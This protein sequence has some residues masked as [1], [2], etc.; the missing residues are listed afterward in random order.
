MRK[1]LL[2]AVALMLAFA[3]LTGVALAADGLHTEDL[4]GALTPDDL[5][6]TLVG[7]GV[8]V[9]GAT[10]TG[11]DVASGLFTGGTGIVGFEEGLLLTSGNAANVIG[12]NVQDGITGDNAAP[13]DAD[14][15]ALIPQ[16]T[17]DASVLEFEF[18]ADADTVYFEYVFASDEYNEYVNTTFNDVFAFFVNGSNCAVAGDPEVPVSVN[19]INGGNPFGTDSTNPSLYINNDLSDGGGSI[20]TEMDGLTVVLVCESVVNPAPA[21]N[22]MKLAIADAGDFILDSAVFIKAGSLSTT[23]PESGTINIVKTV[24][25]QPDGAFDDD[26]S[27]WGFSITGVDG[28]LAEGTSDAAGLVS[29]TDV[30]VGDYDITETPG[31]SGMW[32]VGASCVD[33]AGAP[34]GTG[35]DGVL[36]GAGQSVTGVTVAADA[37][38]T[39]SFANQH[40]AGY[41]TGGGMILDNDDGKIKKQKDFDKVGFGGNVGAAYDGTLHGQMQVNLHNVSVDDLDKGKFH[42]TSI[43]AVWFEELDGLEPAAPP[44]ALYNYVAYSATGR[45]N[46]EDGW[47]IWAEVTDHG[48]PAS[49][50]NAGV[51]EDTYRVQLFNPGGVLVY[52]SAWDF[53]ADA[54]ERTILDN[55]NIQI[56]PL[57]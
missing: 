38:I 22:T 57:D 33:E 40:M 32:V 26:P 2:L 9:S 30:P 5:A 17:N 18:T 36:V 29:F 53:P 45:F 46:G 39:C 44:D 4:T 43:D 48:E 52:D 20:N 50:A 6:Q 31:P 13:G 24:D 10:Y 14:L 54:G 28:L 16:D 55:G 27:G 23:P 7:A 11:A 49:G 8:T 12:P 1:V 19:N 56:H 25:D 3:S 42:S 15:D 37:V 21:T 41:V 35:L 34:V 51:D 47:S